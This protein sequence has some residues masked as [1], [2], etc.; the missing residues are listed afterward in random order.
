MPTRRRK[1]GYLRCC[2]YS[3]ASIMPS[4]TALDRQVTAI[5]SQSSDHFCSGLEPQDQLSQEPAET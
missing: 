1:H 3:Q 5:R 2:E 4:M